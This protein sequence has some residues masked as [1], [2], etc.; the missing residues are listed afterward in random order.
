M[1]S[2]NSAAYYNKSE[3]EFGV[4]TV[5]GVQQKLQKLLAKFQWDCLD[6]GLGHPRR[7]LSML[8]ACVC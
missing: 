3:E 5:R 1:L 2:F 7:H 8:V 6:V 4:E